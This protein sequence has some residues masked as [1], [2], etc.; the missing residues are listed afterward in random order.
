MALNNYI[1][2]V[3]RLLHDPGVQFYS[4][5]DLT[6]YI[7]EA[8]SQIAVESESTRFLFIQNSV[9]GQEKYTFPTAVSLSTGFKDVIQVKG[10]AIAWGGSLSTKPS[11]ALIDWSM[12]Q[13][14]YRFYGTQFTGN[15]VIASFYGKTVYLWPIPSGIFQME[16][17]TVTNVID[18]ATDT[19]AEAIPYPYTD[20]VPFYAAYIALLNAQRPQEAQQMF[21]LFTQ[22]MQ[23]GQAFT[24]RTWTPFLYDEYRG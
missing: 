6:A 14:Q 9:A 24:Q 19:D 22:Y 12:F 4:T 17:D 13:A 11:V 8:R 16:W 23:R 3:Q 15:P 18:L 5:T 20:A 1:T 7:N 10:I 21:Q 2:K